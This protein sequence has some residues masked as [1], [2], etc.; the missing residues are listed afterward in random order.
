M[1]RNRIF[2]LSAFLI[3]IS[4]S[5]AQDFIR[6][7]DDHIRI[8]SYNTENLFDIYDDSTTRDD[9]FTPEGDRR[10]TNQ[11]FYKK[12]NNTAK[13][14]IGVG[15]WE[16]P[17][18]VGLCEIENRFVLNK[19][20]FQTPLKS[21]DYKIIHQDSPDRRGIDIAMIY[22]ESMFEPLI[23]AYINIRFPFD[24]N[25]RTRD[26]LYVKGLIFNR[27]TMHLF[28]NHWP[29]RYG[30]YMATKPK[31]EF[32]ARL[33]RSKVDSLVN[34]TSNPNIL[35]MGD[36]NDEPT[37]ESLVRYLDAKMDTLN[38]ARTDL[39]NLMGFIDRDWKTG[40]SKYQESWNTIDQMIVS[41]NLLKKGNPVY[42]NPNSIK[43]Y[44]SEFLLEDDLKHSGKKPFRTYNGF[45]YSGGFSDHLPIYVNIVK[46]PR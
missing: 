26:I 19:L 16:P 30:G 34:L 13:V 21:F 11:R 46:R 8:M 9:E 20:I 43:I 29:S 7:N 6:P 28:V 31:R 37:D 42:I 3:I 33:L 27:D 17:A 23:S 24:T 25:S 5:Y 10:W 41:G 15:E 35:I 18:I 4:L 36:F 44:N 40:T 22:R 38:I 39:V 12:L 2:L 14:I 1:L 32:V 45:N